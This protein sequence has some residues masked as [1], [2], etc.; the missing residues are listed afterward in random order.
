M[1]ENFLFDESGEDAS[2]A[3]TVKTNRMVLGALQLSLSK[4]N[5]HL[6]G[7]LGSSESTPGPKQSSGLFPCFK[8]LRL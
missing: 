4:E 7:R 5:R 6:R 1:L 3:S 2:D 8:A